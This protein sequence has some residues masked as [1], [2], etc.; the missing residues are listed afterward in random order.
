MNNFCYVRIQNHNIRPFSEEPA[1]VL[2]PH[3]L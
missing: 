3:S 2:A 1:M